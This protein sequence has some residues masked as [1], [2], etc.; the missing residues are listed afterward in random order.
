MDDKERTERQERRREEQNERNNIVVA[1]IFLVM[2]TL[3]IGGC[4]IAACKADAFIIGPGPL[5]FGVDI[6]K[7]IRHYSASRQLPPGKRT[8]APDE[9]WEYDRDLGTVHSSRTRI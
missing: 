8:I 7:I 5:E 2:V 1:C 9:H 4:T 6:S 3:T